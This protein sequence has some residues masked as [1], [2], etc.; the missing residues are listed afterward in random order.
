MKT[1]FNIDKIKVCLK[2]P[3]GFFDDLY[4]TYHSIPVKG[5]KSIH[6]NG[7]Y[8]S[9]DNDAD[10]NDKDITAVLFVGDVQLG[11]FTFNKSRKYGTKCFFVYET[12]SLYEVSG[13]SFDKVGRRSKSNYFSYP[14][15]VFDDLGLQ[16]NNV[17]SVEI[18]CDTEENVFSRIQYAVCHPDTYEMVL[19][20]K[21]VKDPNEVLNGYGEYYQRSRLRRQS[22]PSIY[23]HP[24][25]S[26]PGNYRE[27]NIYDKARE[28]VQSRPDKKDLVHAWNGMGSKVQRIE[29]RVENIPFRQYYAVATKKYPDR[30]EGLE[31]FF[32]DLGQHEEVRAEMFQYFSDNLLHFRIRNHDKTFISVCDLLVNNLTT[33]RMLAERKRRPRGKSAK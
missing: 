33:L 2:Q 9:F 7:Y 1:V 24:E 10:V 21:K 31:H 8:L 14:F 23:I 27:M 15:N 19:L 5:G 16:F 20:G 26:K 6:Y 12:K 30:W 22:Q 17:T 3:E 32:Y 4:R 29:I 25:H 13:Y 28:L 11:T 18:A